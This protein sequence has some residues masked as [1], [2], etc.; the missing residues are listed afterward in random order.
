MVAKKKR[1][2]NYGFLY[3]ISEVLHGIFDK[4]HRLSAGE[5]IDEEGD[6]LLVS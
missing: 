5:L 4:D 1:S 3:T 6:K 2:T